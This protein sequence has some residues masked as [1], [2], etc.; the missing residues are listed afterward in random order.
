MKEN[1]SIEF[2]EGLPN[3]F[4]SMIDPN[5]RNLVVVD[6]LMSECSQNSKMCSLFTR[7]SHHRNLSIFFLVQNMFFSRKRI[8]KH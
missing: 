2:V 7:G 8:K 6:D 5:V 1:P 3:N 4:E